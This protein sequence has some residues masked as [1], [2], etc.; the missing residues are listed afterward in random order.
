MCMV[1]V[2]TFDKSHELER[3]LNDRIGNNAYEPVRWGLKDCIVT[4]GGVGYAYTLI[5]P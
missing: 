3:Y 2:K 5:H 1:T 4:F